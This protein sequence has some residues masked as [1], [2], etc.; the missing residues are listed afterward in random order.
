MPSTDKRLIK[1]TF[2]RKTLWDWEK[3]GY[4]FVS[5]DHKRILNLEASMKRFIDYYEERMRKDM[6]VLYGKKE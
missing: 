1:A 4:I 2:Q 5:S 6:E 3:K